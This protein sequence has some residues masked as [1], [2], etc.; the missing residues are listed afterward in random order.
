MNKLGGK[1]EPVLKPLF[2]LVPF[3]ATS[4]KLL[5]SACLY[6]LGI[7]STFLCIRVTPFRKILAVIKGKG[8]GMGFLPRRILIAIPHGIYTRDEYTYI[9]PSC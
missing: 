6:C 2:E 4:G 8:T 7:S 1:G 3:N 5:F 9:M